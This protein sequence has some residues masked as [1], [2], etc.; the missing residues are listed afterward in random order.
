MSEKTLKQIDAEIA[1]L[2]RMRQKVVELNKKKKRRLGDYG[3]YDC[4]G[5][6]S[7]WPVLIARGDSGVNYK[8]WSVDRDD[9][10]QGNPECKH[11]VGNV[12]DDLAAA[13]PG[14]MLLP[15]RRGD[16]QWILDR[17]EGS[18]CVWRNEAM[19]IQKK[20]QQKFKEQL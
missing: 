15:L 20:V 19:R 3:F 16:V 4:D 9:G 13:G 18:V 12:F 14:G 17:N 10:M 1:E 11:I 6:N 7:D 2:S 5:R 8:L